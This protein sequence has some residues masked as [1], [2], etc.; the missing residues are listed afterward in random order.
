L[1]VENS[2]LSEISE[3]IQNLQTRMIKN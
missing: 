1:K 2:I 3:L